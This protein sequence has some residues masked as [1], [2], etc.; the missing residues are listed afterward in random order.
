VK[1]VVV[2]LNHSR[3]ENR[4]MPD[5]NRRISKTLVQMYVSGDS[6]PQFGIRKI[7]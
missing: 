7:D 2:Y 6:H 5:V 4:W 1:T 3:R